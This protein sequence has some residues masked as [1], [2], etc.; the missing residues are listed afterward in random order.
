MGG[1]G[2]EVL[3]RELALRVQAAHKGAGPHLAGLALDW[4]KSY[5]R[6]PLQVLLQLARAAWIPPA[7]DRR[8]RRDRTLCDGE[9][10]HSHCQDVV[11]R[12]PRA[13]GS[14]CLRGRLALA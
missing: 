2:A 4:S 12:R 8:R 13:L 7:V 3:T 14:A 10:S 5:H 1:G 9:C 11:S 6:L